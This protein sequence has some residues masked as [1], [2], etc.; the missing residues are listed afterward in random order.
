MVALSHTKA[1]CNLA[2]KYC[3]QTR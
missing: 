3:L 1:L 2:T